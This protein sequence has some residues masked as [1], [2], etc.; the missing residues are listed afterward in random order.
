MTQWWL[1]VT[2]SRRGT[3]SRGR[4]GR[5][6]YLGRDGGVRRGSGVTGR[7][8][9]APAVA[10]GLTALPSFPRVLSKQMGVYFLTRQVEKAATC[11]TAKAINRISELRVCVTKTSLSSE[12]FLCAPVPRPSPSVSRDSGCAP[13]RYH[14]TPIREEEKGIREKTVKFE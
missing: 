11:P 8:R 12:G 6:T 10:R 1:F 3:G 13:A 7:A 5:Q 2:H 14:R 9:A 4:G